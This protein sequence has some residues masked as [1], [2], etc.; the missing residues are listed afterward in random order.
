MTILSDNRYALG[1]RSICDCKDKLQS[2][3]LCMHLPHCVIST[4][5]SERRNPEG[6]RNDAEN[7][8]QKSVLHIQGFAILSPYGREPGSLHSA[9]LRWR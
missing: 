4:E 8:V 2:V 5:Q 9:A 7:G 6:R 1:H 3:D